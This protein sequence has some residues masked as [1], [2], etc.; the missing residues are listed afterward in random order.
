MPLITTDT[1]SI[2]FPELEGKLRPGPVDLIPVTK[3]DELN[4]LHNKKIL[5]Y[6][7]VVSQ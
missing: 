5:C 3:G 6:I 4:P 1:T 2:S 7:W